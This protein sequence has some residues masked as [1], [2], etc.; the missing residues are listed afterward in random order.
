MR[1]YDKKKEDQFYE[2]YRLAKETA[3]N[4]QAHESS[5]ERLIQRRDTIGG[6]DSIS[7]GAYRSVAGGSRLG[8]A[9]IRSQAG[10]RMDTKF[11]RRRT[12]YTVMDQES[13]SRMSGQPG[14]G[15]NRERLNKSQMHHK[16]GG[17]GSTVDGG[18]ANQKEDIDY[19]GRLDLVEKALET[20]GYIPKALRDPDSLIKLCEDHIAVLSREKTACETRLKNTH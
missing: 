16:S 5:H 17:I 15:Y 2:A 1:K 11:N 13:S 7:T 10:S 6:G 19:F 12:G 4:L 8:T 14:K 20:T 9:A 18:Q 3:D